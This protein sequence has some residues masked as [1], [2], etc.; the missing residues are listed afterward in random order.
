M[1]NEITNNTNHE[2][3]YVQLSLRKNSEESC[4]IIYIN[5]YF[6]LKLLLFLFKI[7][8]QLKYKI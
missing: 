5:H 6:K 2:K 4:F 1:K 8:F 3:R 7:G